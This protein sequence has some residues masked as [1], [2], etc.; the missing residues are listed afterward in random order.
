LAVDVNY[1][2]FSNTSI[3]NLPL[4]NTLLLSRQTTKFD[5]CHCNNKRQTELLSWTSFC[6]AKQ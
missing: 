4:N 3:N 6:F 2:Q 5:C 1:K